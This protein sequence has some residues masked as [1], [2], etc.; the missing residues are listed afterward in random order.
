MP[1]ILLLLV[2]KQL[3][4]PSTAS[5]R[6]LSIV[7]LMANRPSES[8]GFWF[9]GVSPQRTTISVGVFST[10]SKWSVSCVPGSYADWDSWSTVHSWEPV[11]GPWYLRARY[12]RWNRYPSCR[13]TP[14]HV[15]DGEGLRLIAPHSGWHRIGGAWRRRECG[16]ACVSPNPPQTP[17]QNSSARSP[18][19]WRSSGLILSRGILL[20]QTSWVEGF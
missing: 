1:S 15:S 2:K 8:R 20:T 16:G 5:P 7:A 4:S 19:R 9:L 12:A 11:A 10:T 3:L 18:S 14:C 17:R 13:R 6:S